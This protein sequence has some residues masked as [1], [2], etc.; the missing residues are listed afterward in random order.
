MIG[1]RGSPNSLKNVF[2]LSAIDVDG[3]IVRCRFPSVFNEC[4]YLCG[5]LPGSTIDTVS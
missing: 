4:S 3:D 5:G 1:A 2:Y